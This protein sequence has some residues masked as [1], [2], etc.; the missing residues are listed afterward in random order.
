M[1]VTLCDPNVQENLPRP[2]CGSWWRF[3]RGFQWKQSASGADD[4][5]VRG[6]RS[7]DAA[8]PALMRLHLAELGTGK[9][10]TNPSVMLVRRAIPARQRRDGA[11]TIVGLTPSRAS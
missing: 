9:R 1:S 7:P 8:D 10:K 6:S 3:A 5:T 2:V 11:K 4:R